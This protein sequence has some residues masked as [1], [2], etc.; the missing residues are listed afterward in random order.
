M[1]LPPELERLIVVEHLDDARALKTCAL[2]CGRF[3]C[4]AQTCLFR[5]IH[6]CDLHNLKWQH[7][8][9]ILDV[10]PHIA[11]YVQ[12]LWIDA[13]AHTRTFVDLL[14][15]RQWNTLN[16]LHVHGIRLTNAAVARTMKHLISS[17]ALKTLQ[18]SLLHMEAAV[19]NMLHHCSSTVAD[20]HLQ[21][22]TFPW[23]NSNEESKLDCQLPLRSSRPQIRRLSLFC[24]SNAIEMLSGPHSPLDLSQLTI[25]EY[26]KSPHTLLTPLLQQCNELTCLKVDAYDPTLQKFPLDLPSITELQCQFC[27]NTICDV[28]SQLVYPAHLKTLRLTTFEQC[29]PIQDN[30]SDG[31]LT[32]EQQLGPQIEE[33]VIQKLTSMDTLVVEV[34][35]RTNNVALEITRTIERAMPRLAADGKLAVAF[36]L[37]GNNKWA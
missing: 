8:L 26:Y 37:A 4:W 5:S 32:I 6:L 30:D 19:W 20:L 12:I 15:P 17:P 22:L 27:G 1:S 33:A 7:L 9:N 13:T 10:S 35:V 18:L 3:C 25:L 11:S 29:W 14:V 36:K 34:A 21:V 2:V 28:L 31:R 23:T 24:A 16:T